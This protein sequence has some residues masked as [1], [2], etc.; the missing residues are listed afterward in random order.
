MCISLSRRSFAADDNPLRYVPVLGIGYS[1]RGVDSL[2]CP[3]RRIRCET[4]NPR[5][6]RPRE[7]DSL[8]VNLL[9]ALLAALRASLRLI[10]AI[11]SEPVIDPRS[12][13]LST[14]ELI[15]LIALRS[16]KRLTLLV[17]ACADRSI[18]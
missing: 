14:V 17:D 3:T 1:T 15:E 18:D 12:T 10:F 4:K 5:A 11:P 9:A 6:L 13:P 2:I 7:W 8:A 16:A